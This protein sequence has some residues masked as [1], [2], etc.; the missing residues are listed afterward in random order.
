MLNL[1]VI[2]FFHSAVNQFLLAIM[3]GAP[4]IVSKDILFNG[5]AIVTT[6]H[7]TAG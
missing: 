7:F 1:G 6:K 5:M 4:S 3:A 2:S